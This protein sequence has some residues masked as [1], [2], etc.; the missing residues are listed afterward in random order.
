LYLY[1]GAVF[2]L[3]C[4][5]Q[6]KGLAKQASWALLLLG[7]AAM[8]VKLTGAV[9]LP[10][11][12]VISIWFVRP[13]IRTLLTR[14]AF[15]LLLIAP[16]LVIQTITSG[17]PL[18]P[19]VTLTLPVDWAVPKN[20]VAVVRT[21]VN[22]FPIYGIDPPVPLTF[23]EHTQRIL[24]GSHKPYLVGLLAL[25]LFS[26]A[27]AWRDRDKSFPTIF[28]VSLAAVGLASL[29][30]RPEFRYVFGFLVALPALVL[31]KRRNWFLIVYAATVALL[32]PTGFGGNRLDN[33]RLV[34]YLGVVLVFG[35]ASL[36]GHRL[37]SR[38]L[39]GFLI[40]GQFLR[41]LTT[42][43]KEIPNFVHHPSWLVRPQPPILRPNRVRWAVL[44]N[45]AYKQP[46][47]QWN[48]WTE[49]PCSPTPPVLS[50]M[51]ALSPEIS[52]LST[53]NYRC[54]AAKLS[55]GF[56]LKTTR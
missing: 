49:I 24:I 28:A 47:N 22:N 32:Y 21:S 2:W 46:A 56:S 10:V 13:S 54:G 23:W 35:W 9:L 7:A 17:H 29:I 30:P 40:L 43:G 4:K 25:L 11:L 39:V 8:N 16:F 6:E 26:F 50:R 53:L 42:L 44:G 52:Q 55:C 41:P 33:L 27:L 20:L 36:R 14:G 15:C 48:C 38:A 1:I 12:F 3:A 34:L 19:A 5:W 18:Y 37:P 51:L 45:V 31:A